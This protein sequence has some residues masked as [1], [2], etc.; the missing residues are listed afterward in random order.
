M[1][2]VLRAHW[3]TVVHYS[4]WLDVGTNSNAK[5][6]SL[7]P[8]SYSCDLTPKVLVPKIV[9]SLLDAAARRIGTRLLFD[10]VWNL[11][12]S[13]CPRL[14]RSAMRLLNVTRRVFE[15]LGEWHRVRNWIPWTKMKWYSQF[16][17]NQSSLRYVDQYW[18]GMRVNH[19]LIDA[20][21]HI[22]R[23]LFWM[24]AKSGP[25]WHPSKVWLTGSAT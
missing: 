13:I 11:M 7:T 10:D 8:I 4:R 24:G 23:G 1:L 3:E 9:S 6:V 14:F 22:N 17:H 16:S 18:S 2:A 21:V 20:Y 19:I 5:T 12:V 15:Y 25:W